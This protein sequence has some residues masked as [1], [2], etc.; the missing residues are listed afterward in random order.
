[1]T[2]PL[3]PDEA[4]LMETLGRLVHAL[5]RVLED[6]MIRAN[7]VSMTE[8][9]ALATLCRAPGQQLRMSELAAATGLTPS[10]IT[11]VVDTLRAHG[12][13]TKER[14]DTDA[15]GTIAVLTAA[16]RE[17]FKTADPAY[18]AIARRRILDHIPADA[19]PVVA[20]VL[21]DL[22]EATIAPA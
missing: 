5:P 8:F 16:G 4:L 22:T 19:L 17:R 10:R 1:M 7:G 13:V 21:R 2:D 12:L 18:L 6:D 15:R 9:A 14:H 3:T 11:R 20:D